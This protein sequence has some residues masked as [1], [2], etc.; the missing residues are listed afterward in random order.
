PRSKEWFWERSDSTI[1]ETPSLRATDLHCIRELQD[2]L[3]SL[4]AALWMDLRTYVQILCML[5]NTLNGKD[6]ALCVCSLVSAVAERSMLATSWHLRDAKRYECSRPCGRGYFV[7]LWLLLDLRRPVCMP[8]ADPMLVPA[9]KY[10]CAQKDITMIANLRRLGGAPFGSGIQ[11]DKEGS[12]GVCYSVEVDRGGGGQRARRAR[13]A[14]GHPCVIFVDDVMGAGPSVLTPAISSTTA[15]DAWLGLPHPGSSLQRSAAK[16]TTAST[17]LI[18]EPRPS[19]GFLLWRPEDVATLS[20]ATAPVPLAHAGRHAQPS[21]RASSVA[22]HPPPPERH[23]SPPSKPPSPSAPREGFNETNVDLCT[24]STTPERPSSF[25]YRAEE[26]RSSPSASDKGGGES[27][28]SH[29]YGFKETLHSTSPPPAPVL[30]KKKQPILKWE[31][32]YDRKWLVTFWVALHPCSKVGPIRS[33]G[34]GWMTM[35]LAGGRPWGDWM[36]KMGGAFCLCIVVI[37]IHREQGEKDGEKRIIF[38]AVIRCGHSEDDGG[39]LLFFHKRKFLR[40]SGPSSAG[41][42]RLQPS[43]YNI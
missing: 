42:W 3:R 36:C 31:E 13:L 33:D 32:M 25:E 5:R 9:L 8:R 38:V 23:L 22:E 18:S 40:P 6:Y 14:P 29:Y 26:F 37:V 43:Q 7:Q 15:C 12:A 21:G 10:P 28:A 20:Q 4:N 16:A 24:Q 41:V 2:L 19:G 27:A 1:Q 17:A 34:C 35:A 11:G 39:E 30:H